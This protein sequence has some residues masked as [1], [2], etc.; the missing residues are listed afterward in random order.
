MNSFKVEKRMQCGARVFYS[1]HFIVG[2]E[3]LQ[4]SILIRRFRFISVKMCFGNV[5]VRHKMMEFGVRGVASGFLLP[6]VVAAWYLLA[7]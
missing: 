3:K 1:P 2:R 4:N 6:H 7:K 5:C